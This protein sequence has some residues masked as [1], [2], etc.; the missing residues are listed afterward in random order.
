MST[1][2]RLEKLGKEYRKEL[3]AKNAIIN[4]TNQYNISHTSAVSDGDNQ[5]KHR[6]GSKADID[7]R[8]SLISINKYYKGKEYDSSSA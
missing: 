5:G 8:N 4:P 7:A 3:I 1:E 6:D 2:S